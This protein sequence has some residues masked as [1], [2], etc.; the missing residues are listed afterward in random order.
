MPWILYSTGSS[1]VTIFV[2][3]SLMALSVAYSVVDLP[4]PV[5]PVTRMTP[6]G[7]AM[8]FFHASSRLRMESE[9]IQTRP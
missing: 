1:I 9:L 6:F 3:G 4:E 7:K 5:G 8:S 2:S